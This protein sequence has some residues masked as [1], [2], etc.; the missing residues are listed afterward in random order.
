MKKIIILT[1]LLSVQGWSKNEESFALNEEFSGGQNHELKRFVIANGGGK[2]E[3]GDYRL[4][5]TIGQPIADEF[6]T[7]GE[8]KLRAGFWIIN[9]N[10]VIFVNGFD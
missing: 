3:S 5:S 6:V 1:S 7:S 8:N 9:K 10:D 4:T 2:V